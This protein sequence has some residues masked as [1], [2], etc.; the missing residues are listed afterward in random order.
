MGTPPVILPP[1]QHDAI[2]TKEK[3]LDFPRYVY[4]V[5]R[6]PIGE[7]NMRENYTPPIGVTRTPRG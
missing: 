2:W 1:D 4:G 6:A 7:S 3:P 5:E